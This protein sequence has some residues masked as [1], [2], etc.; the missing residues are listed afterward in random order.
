MIPGATSDEH[1][2][3]NLA[4][5]R[6]DPPV[7]ELTTEEMRRIEESEAPSTFKTWKGLCVE[8]SSGIGKGAASGVSSGTQEGCKPSV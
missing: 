4:L 5:I 3:E 6:N 1:I 7:L 8:S 2:A